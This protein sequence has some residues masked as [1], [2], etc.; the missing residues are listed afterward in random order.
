[1][2]AFQTQLDEARE[3][4]DSLREAS[5]PTLSTAT[6]EHFRPELV[7]DDLERAGPKRSTDADILRNGRSTY[8]SVFPVLLS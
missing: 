1:M 2:N 7:F 5:I 8:A 3:V 4:W 6:K